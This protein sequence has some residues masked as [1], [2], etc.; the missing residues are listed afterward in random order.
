MHRLQSISRVAI[1]LGVHKHPIADGMCKESMDETRSLIEEKVDYTPN[2]KI[3]VISLSVNKTFLA[4]HL[5]DDCSDGTIE[6]F[7]GEQLEH[8]KDK[9]CE[10]NSLNICNLVASFKHCLGG[11]YIDS[12]LE[13][14]SKNRYDYIQECCFP[15][16]VLRQKLFI[17]KM[18]INGVGSRVRLVT[19]I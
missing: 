12:I 17:F 11:G 15:K 4:R 18:L 1:H 13:V 14:K 2:V 10:L 5:F 6:L 19:L 8:I 3:F 16:Q 9:F 7:N